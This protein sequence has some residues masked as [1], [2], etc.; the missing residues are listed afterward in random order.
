MKE[1]HFLLWILFVVT[2]DRL[3]KFSYTIIFEKP[4]YQ[5]PINNCQVSLIR[6]QAACVI[7]E[8]KK[9]NGGYRPSGSGLQGKTD[10]EAET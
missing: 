1:S 4:L 5:T 2:L 8:K 10:M 3:K 7:L 9:R 6:D